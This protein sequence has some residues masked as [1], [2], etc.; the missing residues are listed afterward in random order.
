MK[1]RTSRTLGKLR[2]RPN[3]ENRCLRKLRLSLRS[4]LECNRIARGARSSFYLAFF[5]LPRD[6]RNA[7]FALYAFMRLID[8]V[9]DEPGDL[10][11]KR[12]GLARWRG[13]LDEAIAGETSGHPILAGARGFDYAVPDSHRAT[14]T[15]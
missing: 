12:R 14:S 10:D 5:G 7:L 15:I 6:K 2:W 8:N 9:S 11:A 3:P 13:M 4:Y 1:S